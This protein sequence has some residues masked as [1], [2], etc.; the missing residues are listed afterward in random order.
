MDAA[1]TEFHTSISLPIFEMTAIITA[2]IYII[3][4][5]PTD[6]I[7]RKMLVRLLPE[8][9]IATRAWLIDKGF[10]RHA[11]DNLV[12]SEQLT[13]VVPGVYI[14]PDTRPTWQDL[15]YFLQTELGLNLTIGGLTAL[16]LLGL[17]H[18]L[19]F[20]SKKKIHLYGTD[21]LPSWLTK[22]AIDA[23]FQWHSDWVLIGRRQ[24]TTKNN[25]KQTLQT[26]T[27]TQPWKEGKGG[28]VISS[29]ER[30]LLEVLCDVPDEISF[31]HADQLMQ[32]MTSLSPRSLQALLEQCENIKVRRLFFWLA[33]RQPHAW[34]DKLHPEK[35]SFG[36][37]KRMLV[38]GGTLDKKY[39]I[40]IPKSL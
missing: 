7:R 39:N 12:K 20:A 22:L 9:G 11:L 13:S 2:I 37:G 30:A 14:R 28:L 8:G 24:A 35:I 32:G 29:P 15:V 34:R 26:F 27:L 31:E 4:T 10:T 33:D 36:S 16:D 40:T 21:A 23:E 25:S 3:Q 38:K 6:V 18:Y 5:M 19:P 17:S 1:E